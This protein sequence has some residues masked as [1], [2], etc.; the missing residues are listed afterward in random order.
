MRQFACANCIDIPGLAR[1]TGCS[2]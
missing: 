2:Q 1:G